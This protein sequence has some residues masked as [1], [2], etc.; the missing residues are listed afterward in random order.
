M[1]PDHDWD[2]SEYWLNKPDEN[3]PLDELEEW[4]EL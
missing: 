2:T 1:E 4:L 3:E